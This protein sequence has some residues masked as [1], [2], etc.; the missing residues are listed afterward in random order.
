MCVHIHEFVR[1]LL[2]ESRFSA[3]PVAAVVIAEP[4]PAIIMASLV[5]VFPNHMLRESLA[6]LLLLS[7]MSHLQAVD[8][9]TKSSL[10]DVGIW[11]ESASVA[12]PGFSLAE[13][14]LRKGVRGGFLMMLKCFASTS[15]SRMEKVPL[16]SWAEATK[17]SKLLANANK[18]AAVHVEKGGSSAQVFI[19]RLMFR[20]DT[21]SAVFDEGAAGKG[22]IC[23][24][25]VVAVPGGSKRQR[26]VRSADIA[27]WGQHVGVSC[28]RA[29]MW[30]ALGAHGK[31]SGHA[32]LAYFRG[33]LRARTRGPHLA[34]AVQSRSTDTH[35]HTHTRV[36]DVGR[37]PSG[38][39]HR[40]S[41]QHC[42]PV[43]HMF[44]EIRALKGI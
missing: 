6:K 44:I 40:V 43:P 8:V 15:V 39:R 16:Q 36:F 30:H 34:H 9:A 28:Q 27:S 24:G 3:G 20:R 42:A 23:L 5:A 32:L 1:C 2:G 38:P 29:S 13:D 19:A 12:L 31:R 21:I 17:L 14:L 26:A 18:A 41:P 37:R 4:G 35:T 11:L 33:A 22:A 10:D 25:A 7:D